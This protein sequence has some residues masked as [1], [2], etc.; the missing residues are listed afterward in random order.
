MNSSSSIMSP[1]SKSLARVTTKSPSSSVKTPSCRMASPSSKSPMPCARFLPRSSRW[2]AP[3]RC[4]R[5][6]RPHPRQE[7]HRPP[8]SKISS[9]SPGRMV[10]AS[11][12]VK[13]PT[14]KTVS[15]I[16]TSHSPSMGTPPSSSMS[17]APATKIPWTS[18][19]RPKPGSRKRET[20][21]PKG[22][23][24]KFGETIR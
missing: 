16:P 13:W 15:K 21:S 22:S 18:L 3:H 7:I 10:R 19:P 8:N 12:S 4:R 20:V 9:S 11:P 5:N 17:S 6:P 24:S 1:R 23:P 2:F 14:Y